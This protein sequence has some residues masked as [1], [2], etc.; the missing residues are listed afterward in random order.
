MFEN[1]NNLKTLYGDKVFNIQIIFGVGKNIVKDYKWSISQIPTQINKLLELDEEVS[2]WYSNTIPYNN[3]CPNPDI[4]TRYLYLDLVIC[5][6]NCK[7]QYNLK[8]KPEP[9]EPLDKSDKTYKSNIFNVKDDDD[10]YIDL[11]IIINKNNIE[12]FDSKGRYFCVKL[13]KENFYDYYIKKIN[14]SK[15]RYDIFEDSRAISIEGDG[16]NDEIVLE[17]EKDSTYH[18][19]TINKNI[20]EMEDQIKILNENKMEIKKLYSFHIL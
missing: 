19:Q 12:A 6:Q 4:Y 3:I 18:L 9:P 20:K 7:I 5:E 10:D 11:Q 15:I 2:I 1:L 13:L 17:E 14:N 16:W 8:I